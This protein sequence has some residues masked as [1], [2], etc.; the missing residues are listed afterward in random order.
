MRWKLISGEKVKS[1]LAANKK[2]VIIAL[3]F[4]FG[5]LMLTASAASVGGADKAESEPLSEYK[6]QLEK[7][8]SDIC[9][10]VKGVGKCRVMVTFE[11]GEENVYKGSNLIESRPPKVMGVT[12]VCRGADSDS[13]RAELVGMM[14][15]LFDIG[16]NRVSVL[17]LS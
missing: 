17:R 7:E 4:I 14:C 10:S 16:A 2:W 13:V 8:L 6:A 9:S 11:R 5:V 12:I 3:L 15:A 1:F